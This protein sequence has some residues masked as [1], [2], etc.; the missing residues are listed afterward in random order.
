MK[1]LQFENVHVLAVFDAL[2]IEIP[3]PDFSMT[4]FAAMPGEGLET[5]NIE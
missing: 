2:E 5:A 3:V 4:G 1:F